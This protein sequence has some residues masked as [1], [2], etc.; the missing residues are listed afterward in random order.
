MRKA[1]VSGIRMSE[2]HSGACAGRGKK[3]SYLLQNENKECYLIPTG[4]R[5][6]KEIRN[7][8]GIIIKLD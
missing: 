7:K 2:V 5:L 4:C 3:K 8:C 1:C 6:G